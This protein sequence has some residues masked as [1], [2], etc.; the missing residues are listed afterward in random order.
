MTIH[1]VHHSP[2]GHVRCTCGWESPAPV[3]NPDNAQRFA[4]KHITEQ[5]R[6]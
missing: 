5:A 2:G 3:F 6:R 4:T 1:Q